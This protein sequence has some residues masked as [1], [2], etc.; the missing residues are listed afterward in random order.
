[1]MQTFLKFINSIGTVPS[2]LAYFENIARFGTFLLK[3]VSGFK[4]G[5]R[6]HSLEGTIPSRSSFS[7]AKRIRDKK[8][9]TKYHR[10]WKASASPIEPVNVIISANIIVVYTPFKYASSYLILS[11]SQ[12]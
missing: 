10:W 3:A 7:C 2:P 1:M 9:K 5:S 4:C 6:A 11:S 8:P 12:P